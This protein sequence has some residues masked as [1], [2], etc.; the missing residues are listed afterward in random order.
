MQIPNSEYS[1]NTFSNFKAADCDGLSKKA[2][3]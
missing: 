3:L 2:V 1:E